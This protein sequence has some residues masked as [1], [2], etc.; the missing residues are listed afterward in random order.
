ME[1]EAAVRGLALGRIAAVDGSV[2]QVAAA[3]AALPPGRYGRMSAGAYGC[4]LS[5][6][7]AWQAILDSGA[8]WGLVLEDDLLMSE[9]FPFGDAPQWFPADAEIVKA[10]TNLKRVH[11][12]TRHVPGPGGAA[13]GRLK[14]TSTAAGCYYLSAGK[15]LKMLRATAAF[16]DGVDHHLFDWDFDGVAD[17]QIWQVCPAPAIQGSLWRHF[18]RTPQWAKRSIDQHFLDRP[19]PETWDEPVLARVYRRIREE[20]RAVALGSR[21]RVIP[22]R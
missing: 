21:Y 12:G 14:S 7:A 1:S 22:F 16:R 8:P 2:P 10:E 4:F 13:I 19:E 11:F 18:D 6:R 9:V 15:A 17:A 20:V 5:H 3:A